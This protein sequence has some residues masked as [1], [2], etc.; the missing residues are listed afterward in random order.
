MHAS[1]TL[2]NASWHYSNSEYIPCHTYIYTHIHTHTHTHTYIHVPQEVKQQRFLQGFC[3]NGAK[4]FIRAQMRTS[5][6]QAQTMAPAWWP[7]QVN[8]CHSKCL[9]LITVRCAACITVTVTI[10]VRENSLQHS[11]IYSTTAGCRKSDLLSNSLT[12]TVAWAA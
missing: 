12:P 7:S 3:S 8:C 11:Y 4:T 6:G 10:T 2:I 5:R 1:Y 9:N